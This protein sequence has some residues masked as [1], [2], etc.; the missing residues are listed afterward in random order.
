MAMQ[1]QRL[2]ARR[3]LRAKTDNVPSIERAARWLDDNMPSEQS[4]AL[5]HNDFKYD[6]VVLI[7]PNGSTSSLCLIGKWRLSAIR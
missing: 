6:N 2:L 5:I 3:Y 1:R 7:R 4:A